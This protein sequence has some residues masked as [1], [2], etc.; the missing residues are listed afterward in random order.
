MSRQ[1]LVRYSMTA[2]QQELGTDVNVVAVLAITGGCCT[3]AA[4]I[5][6]KE[7]F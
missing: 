3:V 2:L 7:P 6:W 4:A 5:C 1:S